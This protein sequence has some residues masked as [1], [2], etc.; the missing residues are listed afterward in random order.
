MQGHHDSATRTRWKMAAARTVV[1]VLAI[2][3]PWSAT[4]AAARR[5]NGFQIDPASVPTGEFERGGPPR[6]GIPALADPER[7]AAADSPWLDSDWV[8]GVEI[9][10]EARAYPVAILVWHELVN[11]ELGGRPIV[12]SY[13]PLCG[14]ALVF[15]R[16][17]AGRVRL[18]GVS[19]LLYRS[20]LLM[21]DRQS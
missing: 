2:A 20:D 18:F 13:C 15:E 6:D 8:V 11:D 14:T 5:L 1:L 10:G 9:G 17:V 19:G 7:L 21:F 3:S 16:E 4:P 12:V